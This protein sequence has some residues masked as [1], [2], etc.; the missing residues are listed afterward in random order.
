MIKWMLFVFSC[1]FVGRLAPFFVVAWVR[2]LAWLGLAWLGSRTTFFFSWWGDRRD[3]LDRHDQALPRREGAGVHCIS[4][5]V[6]AA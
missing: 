3:R 6:Y 1:V 4:E 5:S 2:V